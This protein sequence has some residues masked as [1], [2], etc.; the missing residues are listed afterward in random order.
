MEQII[1][2]EELLEWDSRFFGYGVGRIRTDGTNEA[3]IDAQLDRLRKQKCRL[4]YVF[5]PRP[6][7]LQG[8]KTLLVDRKRSYILSSPRHKPV[9]LPVVQARTASPELY[10]LACQAGEYSRFRVD[11]D[12]PKEYG[13]RLYHQ[14][15]D[16]SLSGQFADFVLTCECDGKPIGLVTAGIKGPELS[17]GLIATDRAFRCRGIGGSLIQTIINMAAD[18]GLDVEVTTQADNLDACRFYERHGFR[19]SSQDFV[20]HIWLPA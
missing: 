4:V 15:L 19:T 5:S 10:D 6:L 20:Y 12:I 11:P 17:I 14:W 3:E 18:R 9:E 13:M 7:Q 2:S 16:N 1:K 8:F